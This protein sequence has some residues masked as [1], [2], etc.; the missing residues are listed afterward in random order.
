MSREIQATVRHIDPTDVLGT[1]QRIEELRQ[2]AIEKAR[3]AEKAQHDLED[4]EQ[5]TR[6]QLKKWPVLLEEF[7]AEMADL[8]RRRDE[9]SA[10][11]A[12]INTLRKQL[13]R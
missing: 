2:Q 10:R 8:A 4:L 5:R 3:L 1:I 6:D 13:P 12:R 7:E 9:R 11:E